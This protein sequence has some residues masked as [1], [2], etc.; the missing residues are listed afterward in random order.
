M[1]P[2]TKTKIEEAAKRVFDLR[3]RKDALGM[4]NASGTT[5]EERLKWFQELSINSYELAEAE[6]ELR[7]VIGWGMGI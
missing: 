6:K 5:Y 7:D 2:E 1:D 3:V 4:A